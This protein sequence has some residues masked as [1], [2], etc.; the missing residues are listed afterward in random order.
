MN[1]PTRG[2]SAASRGCATD[3][4]EQEKL[5]ALQSL[6]DLGPA[7]I[8]AIERAFDSLRRGT[9]VDLRWLS[10]AY[11]SILGTEAFPRLWS[12]RVKASWTTAQFADYSTFDRFKLDLDESIALSLGLTS[13]VAST[14]F[15]TRFV[16][17][18]Q[19]PRDALDRLIFGWESGDAGQVE[20]SLGP[21]AKSALASLL[22]GR[23]WAGL[24]ADLWP[25]STSHIVEENTSE[26][27][28]SGAGSVIQQDGEVPAIGYRFEIPHPWSAPESVLRFG[29]YPDGS[30]PRPELETQFATRS[31][32]KC[33]S[34][35]LRFLQVVSGSGPT[36]LA[37][38]L[39]DSD[40]AGTLRLITY[41]ARQSANTR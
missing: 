6:I 29:Q 32:D 25:G 17:R 34:R 9:G 14:S 26:F 30:T 21:A 5:A 1:R 19:Q 4:T 15:P 16:C 10:Y 22:A 2:G 7:A 13:W 33:G 8:P 20:Q 31:G 18:S 23:T 12:M 40:L 24:R 41:C 35:R 11:A 28:Q 3:Q 39:D 36:N 37:Y 38:V 27:P